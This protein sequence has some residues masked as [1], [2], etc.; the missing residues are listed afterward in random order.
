MSAYIPTNVISITDGQL[1]LETEAFNS[2]IRPAINPGLSVSRVG[3]SAQTK[4]MK[5][6]AGPIRTELA[7][8]RELASFSQ[9]SSDLD[10]D[11]RERLNHGERIVEIMK[12]KQ[13]SPVS[14]EHMILV[15][16]AASSK[17]FG[18]VP[19]EKIAEYENKIIA[20][21]EENHPDILG[22]IRDKKVLT[23]ELE[24][25][26]RDALEKFKNEKESK[27]GWEDA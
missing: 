27:A 1:Y 26:M 2:G 23:E 19:K 4:A 24:K 18:G 6:M 22:E 12:Q 3:G 21:F 13:Y 9:L 11:T 16:F 17:F 5:K 15:L 20:Y 14:Q 25:K 7:Q 10:R 8:Y